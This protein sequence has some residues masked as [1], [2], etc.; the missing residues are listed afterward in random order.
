M[1]ISVITVCLNSE[2]TIER[3][4][5]SVLGQGDNCEYIIIDG[6]STDRT[7]E[8]IEKYKNNISILVSEPD[9]GLYD[10]MNKG[11]ML[12]SGDIIG[13]IN[14]DDW[15]E[16]GTFKIVKEY[17]Q[18]FDAE[19]VYGKMN[20]VGENGEVTVQIP[21]DIEKLRYEMQTPHSTVFVKKEIYEQYGKFQLKYKISADYDLMLRLYTGGVKFCFCDKVLANFQLGGLAMQQAER[22]VEETLIISSNYLSYIPLEKR[23]YFKQKIRNIYMEFYFMKMLNE[24]PEDLL[25]ILH[26]KLGMALKDNIAIFGA[27]IWGKKMYQV[28]LQVKVPPLFIV[29]NNEKKWGVKDGIRVLQPEILKSFKGVLLLVVRD[30]TVTILTQ[31]ERL[32]NLELYCITWEEIVAE[33][34][35][36]KREKR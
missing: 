15:Y 21:T 12:A 23:G 7:L 28:L 1:K 31:I 33:Y 26:R 5:R 29:D 27:G 9:D 10:A 22:C 6:G 35:K 36:L 18:E 3:T 13:I 4:I 14:S 2:R 20:L 34:I 17:F 16:P 19:V 24:D 25:D 30:F 8:I 32:C 11:I